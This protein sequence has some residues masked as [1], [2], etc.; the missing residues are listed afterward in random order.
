MYITTSS[1]E[2]IGGE[3]AGRQRHPDL[4]DLVAQPDQ[5]KQGRWAWPIT[6]DVCRRADGSGSPRITGSRIVICLG[7]LFGAGLDRFA[8]LAIKAGRPMVPTC[9][10]SLTLMVLR[11][12]SQWQPIFDGRIAGVE[13]RYANL[14]RLSRA[15]EAGRDQGPMNWRAAL[16]GCAPN[17]LVL[18]HVIRQ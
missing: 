17:D 1:P 8:M 12:A 9:L 7:R 5:W 6:V 2:Q 14:A 16:P 15:R 3:M 13:I 4:R 11:A 10:G 18:E